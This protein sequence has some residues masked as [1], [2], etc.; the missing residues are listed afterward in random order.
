MT[1]I[2]AEL[3]QNHNGDLGL[4]KSMV[5]DAA[6][7]GADYV[8]IQSMLADDLSKRDRFETGHNAIKRPYQEEY[9]RLK[10]LDLDDDAHY[11]FIEECL[12][13]NV[14]PLTTAFNRTR[15]DFLA[16]LPWPERSIKISSFDCRSH[17]MIQELIDAGF[18]KFFVSTGTTYDSEIEETTSI[19]NDAGVEFTLF[20]CVSIYPSSPDTAHLNRINF[21]RKLSKSVGFSEHSSYDRD[22]LKLAIASL[23]YDVDY[24]ERHFTILPKESTKDGIVSLNK[25]EMKELSSFCQK[26]KVDILRYIEKNIPDYELM[27]GEKERGLSYEE[28]RNRD[29]Y[30]GRFLNRQEDKTFFNWE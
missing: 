9:D 19:L 20:H 1:K 22:G 12:K 27:K 17:N 5:K 26:D 4:L 7:A 28:I 25:K 15:I 29:Y 3:C 23:S 10:T 16:N 11:M 2:I 13:H 18:E 8:K 6:E 21:L 14:K 30:Q 24:I